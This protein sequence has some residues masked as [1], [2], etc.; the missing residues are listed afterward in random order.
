MKPYGTCTGNSH[1]HDQ[2]VDDPTVA[3]CIHC[4]LLVEYNENDHEEDDWVM[5]LHAYI[6]EEEPA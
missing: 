5:R 3:P 6:I 1:G 2:H 4:G